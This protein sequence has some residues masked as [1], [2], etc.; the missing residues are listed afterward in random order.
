MIGFIMAG[1]SPIK[2]EVSIAR[3]L[4][5]FYGPWLPALTLSGLP[6]PS[7]QDETGEIT[8]FNYEAIFRWDPELVT[9]TRKH[10]IL[11]LES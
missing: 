3:K 7:C 11:R 2:M 1:K 10:E 5:Y 9:S 6:W 4:S 8:S